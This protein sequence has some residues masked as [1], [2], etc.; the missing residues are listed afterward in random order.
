M[1]KARVLIIPALLIILAFGIAS[2]LQTEA[3][4][5]IFNSRRA[6]EISSEGQRIA[7]MKESAARTEA[8]NRLRDE[9]ITIME[10][11]RRE[12]GYDLIF[13]MAH[14]G[15]V[16]FNPGIDITEDVIG[17]LRSTSPGSPAGMN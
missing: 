17:R 6:F 2:S 11:L 7:K 10:S 14:G 12:R 13:D 9:M 3:K 1:K 5:V 4:I 16:V 8:I 15:V